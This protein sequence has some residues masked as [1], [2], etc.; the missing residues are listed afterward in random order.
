M[1]TNCKFLRTYTSP[2]KYPL[3]PIP[4]QCV[5]QIVGVNVLDLLKTEAGNKHVVVFQDFL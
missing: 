1:Y 2:K 4:V 5:F 3:N